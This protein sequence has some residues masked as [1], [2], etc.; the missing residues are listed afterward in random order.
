MSII[1]P[2]PNENKQINQGIRQDPDNPEWTDEMFSR[3]VRGPQK[4]PTKK[5]ITVRFDPD[6][7]DWFK[8]QGAGYQSRMNEALRRYMNKPDCH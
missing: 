6:I 1:H 3:V 2:D 8:A 4:A 5:Q 7:I